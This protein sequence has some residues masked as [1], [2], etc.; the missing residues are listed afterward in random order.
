MKTTEQIL[1]WIDNKLEDC[2]GPDMPYS[3]DAAIL[4]DAL[5]EFITEPESEEVQG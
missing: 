3:P 4:L 5:R 2:D 1:E